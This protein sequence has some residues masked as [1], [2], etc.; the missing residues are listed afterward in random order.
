MG[1]SDK[2]SRAP[3][4]VP[5]VQLIQEYGKVLVENSAEMVRDL[6]LLP[7]PAQEIGLAI[8]TAISKTPDGPTKE[9][10]RT[11]F[12]ELASFMP[13]SQSEKSVLHTWSFKSADAQN[14]DISTLI[15]SISASGDTYTKLN[16]KVLERQSALMNILKKFEQR[17]SKAVT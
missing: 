1:F 2:H 10:L 8:L 7:A 5:V 6:K 14:E 11:G 15:T 9:M 12:V 3:E 13:L 17:I 4:P 16:E